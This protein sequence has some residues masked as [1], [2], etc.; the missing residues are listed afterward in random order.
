MDFRSSLEEI[1]LVSD[2]LKL[3]TLRELF[4]ILQLNEQFSVLD[5]NRFKRITDCLHYRFGSQQSFERV[6]TAIDM[7][8]DIFSQTSPMQYQNS[9]NTVFYRRLTESMISPFSVVCQTCGFFIDTSNVKQ[10]RVKVYW[11]NGAV[12]TGNYK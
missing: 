10:R 4:F 11:L 12:L 8:K 1:G 6:K 3:F 2:Q 5:D 7:L 9:L